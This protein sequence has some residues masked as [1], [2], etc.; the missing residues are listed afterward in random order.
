MPDA[1]SSVVYDGQLVAW[2]DRSPS[3]MI[4]VVALAGR[5]TMAA[6]TLGPNNLIVLRTALRGPA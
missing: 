2:C 6:I 5:A 1:S 4:A 3:R